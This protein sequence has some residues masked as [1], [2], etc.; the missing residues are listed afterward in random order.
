MPALLH[1]PVGEDGPMGRRAPILYHARKARHVTY[2]VYAHVLEDPRAQ[3]TV[4]ESRGLDE[5]LAREERVAIARGRSPAMAC[6]LAL[7]FAR[8]IAR[9]EAAN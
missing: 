7:H 5:L 6:L 9:E 1:F 4:I 2:S 3:E 8:E